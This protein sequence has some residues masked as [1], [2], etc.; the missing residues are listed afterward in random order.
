MRCR[1][2]EVVQ[3][4]VPER[5]DL[6]HGHARRDRGSGARRRARRL[7]DVGVQAHR[8][9]GRDDAP[10]ATR[11]RTPV[12]P[13]VPA[14]ARRGGGW[15]AN[16]ARHHRPGDGDVRVARDEARSTSAWRSTRS[17]PTGFSKRSGA[18]RSGS[19][20]T[21]SPPPRRSTTRSATGS[22]CGGRRWGCSRR[23]G[24]PAE[25]AGC[26]TSSASSARR[27]SGRGRS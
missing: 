12:Q 23:I 24:P 5:L 20:T 27:W 19:S 25:R 11:R 10:R 8:P 15:G 4:C 22:D 2:V 16:V 3:E 9:R 1:G 6:K 17:S 18:K 7:V 21:A 14:A 26:A 13:G